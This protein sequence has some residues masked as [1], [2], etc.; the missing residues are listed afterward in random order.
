MN[1]QGLV[2]GYAWSP[3]DWQP[4]HSLRGFRSAFPCDSTTGA[5]RDLNT[6]IPPDLSWHLVDTL[7]TNDRGEIV[8]QGFAGNE[9][10][11]FLLIPE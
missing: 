2:V 8:G 3:E 10:H 9:M 1:N 4:E 6:L 5:T 7:A 11:A